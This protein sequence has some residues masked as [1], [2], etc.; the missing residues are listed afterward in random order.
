MKFKKSI[1][2]MLLL[3]NINY[4]I[5]HTSFEINFDQNYN[6]QFEKY[7]SFE[8]S[9]QLQSIQ[10]LSAI[11]ISISAMYYIDDAYSTKKNRLVTA[12]YPYAQAWYDEMS[13]KYPEA[14]FDQKKFLPAD[15]AQSPSFYNIYFSDS[16]LI[17]INNLY[18]KK[19]ENQNL[20]DNEQLFM[21]QNEFL[22]L[23]QAGYIEQNCAFNYRIAALTFFIATSSLMIPFLRCFHPQSDIDNIHKHKSLNFIELQNEILQFQSNYYILCLAQLIF[24]F[25]AYQCIIKHYVNIAY[26]FACTHCDKDCLDAAILLFE[27]NKIN[28]QAIKDEIAR[29]KQNQ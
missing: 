20:T 14:H 1:F 27:N 28:P 5:T 9:N 26:N 22:L 8:Q 23:Y 11:I 21:V 13:I 10:L 25:P 12:I 3:L 6:N 2:L 16:S 7:V 18:K 24:T 29:R 19:L 4:T 15:Y 17:N